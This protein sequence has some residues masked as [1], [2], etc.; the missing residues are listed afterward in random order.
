MLSRVADSIYWMSRYVERAE[1]IARF[2]DVTQSLSL[3]GV[4]VQWSPLVYASGD[5]EAFRKAYGESF[6]REN[7]LRFLLLDRENPNSLSFCVRAARENARAIRGELTTAMWEAVNRFYLRVREAEQD[8]DGVLRNPHALIE[9]VKRSSHQ[10]IGVTSA[11]FSHNEAWSFSQLGR[12]LERG[13]KTSRILD[14][15]YFTLLPDPSLVGSTLDVVQW[16]AL[17]ESTSALHM[18]RKR[19]GRIGPKQVAEFLVLDHAFPRSMQ[20]CIRHAEQCLRTITG[21]SPGFYTNSAEQ[22]MGQLTSRLNYAHIDQIINSGLHEFVD[23][24]QNQVNAIGEAIFKTFFYVPPPQPSTP[25]SATQV[26]L[27]VG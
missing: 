3:G 1:N 9:R 17:L 8:A 15:K 10:V 20:F 26:Q 11:T 5:E 23:D 16:S 21:A 19:Y 7:V 13:D 12:L 18:Y 2:I 22:L 6:T 24:F 25:P 27:Q 4:N 14:V